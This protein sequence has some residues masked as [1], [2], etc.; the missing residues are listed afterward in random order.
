[1]EL[2]WNKFQVMSVNCEQRLRRPDGIA[3]Q[4][5]ERMSYLGATV[6]QDVH[7]QHELVRRIALSKGDFLALSAVWRRSA[8]TQTRKLALYVALVESRLL[9]G[10]SSLC[11]TVAQKRKLDG[12]Q[13]RCLRSIFGIK[14]AFIS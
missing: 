14:P 5:H 8:L 4:T 7:D 2:H 3:L 6:S 1:M 12:F 11:L 9:Y 13:C 10:L